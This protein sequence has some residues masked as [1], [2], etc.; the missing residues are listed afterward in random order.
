MLDDWLMN[1]CILVKWLLSSK[2]DSSNKSN[3]TFTLLS[4]LHTTSVAVLCRCLFLIRSSFF[5]M[6][7]IP[8]PF[9]LHSQ[10][11][12]PISMYRSNNPVNLFLLRKNL[13]SMIYRKI[14]CHTF[15]IAHYNL[16]RSK[17]D[18]AQTHTHIHTFSIDHFHSMLLQLFLRCVRTLRT[19][20][21]ITVQLILL[22]IFSV[23]YAINSNN[24][25]MLST[26]TWLAHTSNLSCLTF[27]LL[28]KL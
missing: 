11:L 12:R 5:Y 22:E 24:I 13:G 10:S 23:S 1:V 7:F 9:S 20:Y 2:C 19:L 14:P 16:M 3:L 6:Y 28:V 26:S 17:M 8:C 21:N 15:S 27:Y 25:E 4:P 18:D